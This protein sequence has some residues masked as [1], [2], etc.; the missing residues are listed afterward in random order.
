MISKERVG[1]KVIKRYDVARTPY[2]RLLESGVLEEA[3]RHS[4]EMEYLSLNP[5][6]LLSKIEDALLALWKLAESE[7]AQSWDPVPAAIRE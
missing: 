7:Q 2:Q 6:L 3:K 4:L 5:A 1:A